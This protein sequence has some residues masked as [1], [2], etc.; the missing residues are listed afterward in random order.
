MY[1]QYI[2]IKDF[3]SLFIIICLLCLLFKKEQNRSKERSNIQV[4]Y[5][6]NGTKKNVSHLK[7]IKTYFLYISMTM[8]ENNGS[9][10]NNNNTF[11]IY[12]ESLHTILSPLVNEYI[13]FLFPKLLYRTKHLTAQDL[14]SAIKKVRSYGFISYSI[15]NILLILFRQ[16]C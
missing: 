7:Y 9:Y 16:A 5:Q 12:N 14:K 13:V 6:W 11:L 3:I 1:Q 8:D 2:S 4:R 10:T 15:I